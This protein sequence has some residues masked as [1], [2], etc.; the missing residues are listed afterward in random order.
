MPPKNRWST[1]FLLECS[2]VK[3]RQRFSRT[4][5]SFMNLIS[6]APPVFSPSESSYSAVAPKARCIPINRKGLFLARHNPRRGN[7]YQI[8][9]LMCT[10]QVYTGPGWII[11]FNAYTSRTVYGNYYGFHWTITQV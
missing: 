5:G 4:K 7:V 9:R 6:G 1:Y 8:L 3:E 10:K 2:T 11:A